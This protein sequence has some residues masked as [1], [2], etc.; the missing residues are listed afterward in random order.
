MSS[1]FICRFCGKE[2]KNKNSLIQHEVRCKS[3]PDRI[4]LSYM[5]EIH[6]NNKGRIP[7][8]KGLTKETD[9]RVLKYSLKEKERMIKYGSNGCFGLKGNNNYACKENIRQK[10][11]I[12]AKKYHSTHENNSVG[13]GKRGWYKG[14]HCQ[15]SWEL[16]YVIYQLE[17]GINI[18]RN[19][20]GFKYTWNGS[21]HTYYPDFYLPDLNQYIEIK[22][23]YSDRDK[24]K[25]EQ[26]VG[27]ILVLQRPQLQYILDYVSSFYGDDYIKLYEGC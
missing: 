26:F 13:K 14:I 1:E 22:G 16:A 10:I 12:T 9:E 18:I 27:N 17:H 25:I 5:N 8:N 24:C 11:S 21:E 2:W 7:W 4:D 3:N 19:K 6:E 15:S 20:K 23:Y